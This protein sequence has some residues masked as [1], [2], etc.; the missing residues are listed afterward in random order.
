MNSS[1]IKIEDLIESKSL[2]SNSLIFG[3]LSNLNDSFNNN[4]ENIVDCSI[5]DLSSIDNYKNKFFQLQKKYNILINQFEEL[6]NFFLEISNILIPINSNKVL[7]SI[8]ERIN[9]V[10][11]KILKNNKFMNNL[12]F[13]DKTSNVK[14]SSDNK[15]KSNYIRIFFV[16]ADKK[17]HYSILCKETDKFEK[18]ENILYEKYPQNKNKAMKFISNGNIIKSNKNLKENKIKDSDII[19]VY[20]YKEI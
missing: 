11:E 13:N 15:L 17:I 6:K 7:L 12:N 5:S 19:T 14:K 20:N 10:K 18:I 1:I 4:S 8:K 3:Q 9:K 2:E 16:S